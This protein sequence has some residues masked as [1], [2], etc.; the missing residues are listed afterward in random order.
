MANKEQGGGVSRRRFL[1]AAAM[2]SAAA[3]SAVGLTGRAFAAAP[4]T[5]RWWSTQSAPDQLKAYRDQIAGF[6]KLHPDIKVVFEPTS[7]EGYPA[8]FAAAFAAKQVPDIVTHLPSYA[9]QTYYAE[10]LLEPMDDVVAK[11]GEQNYY[12]NAN[13][14][15]RAADGK[16]CAT[17]LANT[18]ADMLWVRRDLMQKAGIEKVP[19][20]WDEL[21]NAC[22]KMQAGRIYGAP[23]PY[24]LNSMTSLIML[25][26]IH[27]AGGQVFTPDLQVAIDSAETRNAL[28]FYKSMR[29]FTPPGATGYSWGESLTAFVSGATATG[30]YGG[31]VLDNIAT[32]NPAIAGAVTC[33]TYPTVSASVPAWTYNDFPCVFIPRG[34]KNLAASKAFA[35]YLFDPAGYIEE[36]LGAPGQLLPV[37]KPISADS[38]YIGNP[39]ISKY[40]DDIERMSTAAAAGHNLGYESP[41]HKA[42]RRANEIVASNALAEMVQRVVLNGE[43]PNTVVPATAK[44]LDALMKAK[45]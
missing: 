23:L 38:R 16:L 19:Q 12:P 20:T 43:A 25:G 42:N 21:R 8:Q 28:E 18:A 29:E 31:R 39:I 35:A 34:V 37:L 14:V 24:G 33:A 10:G 40:R 11:I 44:K 2:G 7:D 5:L 22:R 9:A 36:L 13:D 45:G 15:F 41:R 4:V 27:R 1:Q 17:G 32:Q 30:I 26:F 6:M 3:W